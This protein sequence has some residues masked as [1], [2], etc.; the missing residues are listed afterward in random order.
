MMTKTLGKFLTTSALAAGLLTVGAPASADFLDYTVHEGVVPGSVVNNFVADKLNGGYTELITFD[1]VGGFKVSAYATFGQYF[2]NEGTSLVTP[3]QVNSIGGY[4]I[5]ALFT[6]TGTFTGGNLVGTSANVTLYLDPDQ[7]TLLDGILTG[8][9]AGNMPTAGG[10]TGDDLAV[11]TASTLISGVGIPG[12]P[13]TFD[14]KFSD[15]TL[16]AFG[17][18][19]WTFPSS[20][21]IHTTVDGDIDEFQLSGTQTV[22]GDLSVVFNDATVPEP[23]TLSLLGL[24]LGSAAWARRRKQKN[25]KS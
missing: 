25:A 19:Y 10:T 9:T 22:T 16:T 13:G 20:L 7:D 1:G 23:A 5:Y 24:G 17:A 15:P 18:T 3:T 21:L 2:K 8:L 6:A 4:G 12:D 11:L 14:F